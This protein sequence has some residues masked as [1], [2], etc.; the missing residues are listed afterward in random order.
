MSGIPLELLA[1]STLE[2]AK[3]RG[4][5]MVCELFRCFGWGVP[6]EVLQQC[7]EN[8]ARSEPRRECRGPSR[9]RPAAL[10]GAA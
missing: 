2:R 7:I 5:A 9:Q 4:R 10:R 8:Q 3:E 1:I 6:V